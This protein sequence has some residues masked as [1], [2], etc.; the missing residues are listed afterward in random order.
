MYPHL[1]GVTPHPHRGGDRHP[2]GGGGKKGGRGVDQALRSTA[3]PDT[4]DAQDGPVA[5]QRQER[6]LHLVDGQA[7]HVGEIGVNR[8]GVAALA[9]EKAI[10]RPGYAQTARSHLERHRD[11]APPGYELAVA[12]SPGGT[13]QGAGWRREGHDASPLSLR[14]GSVASQASMSVLNH[15]DLPPTTRERGNVPWRIH[16]QR[17]G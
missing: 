10:E 1:L 13:R 17:V 12:L 8:I 2:H 3:W 9:V 5:L 7:G 15:M 11:A 6:V 16:D 14:T 4:G